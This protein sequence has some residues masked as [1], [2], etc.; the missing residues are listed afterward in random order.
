[1]ALNST[2]ALIRALKSSSDPPYAGGPSKIH[3]A[4]DAWN[5]SQSNPDLIVDW[6]LTKLLKDKSHVL[7]SPRLTAPQSLK[8]LCVLLDVEHWSLLADILVLHTS[9]EARPLKTWILPILN[10]TP[11]CPIITNFLNLFSVHSQD[12]SAIVETCVRILWPLT[13]QKFSAENLLEAFGA[14][15]R[16]GKL[17]E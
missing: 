6:I 7:V 8:G 2:Q 10:R 12:L 9:R 17:C 4:R 5:S 15:F 1:M 3:I 11:F 14:V 16:V 13:V